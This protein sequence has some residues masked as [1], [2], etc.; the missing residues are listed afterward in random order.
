MS[1]RISRSEG[2]ANVGVDATLTFETFN[3]KLQQVIM[4][5]CLV[6]Y[7]IDFVIIVEKSFQWDLAVLHSCPSP[8]PEDVLGAGEH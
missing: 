5:L 2:K 4:K 7:C 8:H 6:F 3:N 1:Q